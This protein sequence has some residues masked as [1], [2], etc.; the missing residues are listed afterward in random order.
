MDSQ[1][2]LKSAPLKHNK[3]YTQAAHILKALK[4]RKGSIG[5]LVYSSKHPDYLL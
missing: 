1:S 5:T 4:E 3:L 2:S